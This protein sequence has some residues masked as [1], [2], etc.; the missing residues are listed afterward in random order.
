MTVGQTSGVALYVSITLFERA[1]E[2]GD[3][4]ISLATQHSWNWR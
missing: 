3:K 2:G 4:A 1:I